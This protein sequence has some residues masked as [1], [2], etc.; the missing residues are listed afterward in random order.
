[1]DGGED[2]MASLGGVECEAHGFWFAHF[3]DH[4]NV[5]VFAQCIQ[6]ALL[7]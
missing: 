2:Q 6:Q 5:R 3:A 4:Q 7:K 1:M